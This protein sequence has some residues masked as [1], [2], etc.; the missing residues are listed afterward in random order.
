MIILYDFLLTGTNLSIVLL[1]GDTL[2][3]IWSLMI[4]LKFLLSLSFD[5]LLNIVV[6]CSIINNYLYVINRF[7]V[8]LQMSSKGTIDLP[9]GPLDEGYSRQ[10]W[11]KIKH[12]YLN[13]N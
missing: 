12:K 9:K 4:S 1:L 5:T 2:K 10:P 8:G 7:K 11:I 13:S 3:L 6:Y